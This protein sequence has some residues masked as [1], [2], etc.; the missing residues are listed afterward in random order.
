MKTITFYSYKGGVGRSLALSNI[1]R[2]LS[3]L[4]KKVCIIDFDLDAPG[5]Q[6]KFKNNY[7]IPK[8]KKGLVDY[9]YEFSL[10][11][12]VVDHIRDFSV[13]LQSKNTNFSSIDLISAGNIHS[14]EYWKKLSMVSWADMFYGED[15]RGIR[16]FL[17][18]KYKIETELQPDF[19][20]IDSRTGITDISGITLRLFADEAVVLAVNNDENIFGSK[21]IIKNLLDES[22][23]LFGKI[24]KINFVLTRIP[25]KD[26]PEDKA[27]KMRVLDNL[28]EDF[29]EHLG[30]ENFTINLI[31]SDR[32][33]EEQENQ[34]IG[35]SLEEK[36]V[37]ISNDYLKLFKLLTSDCL[38]EDELTKL[39]NSKKA[40]EEYIKG[41]RENDVKQ[42]LLHVEKAIK[43]DSSNAKYYLL[44]GH[45]FFM[46]KKYDESIN[47]QFKILELVKDEKGFSSIAISNLASIYI[48]KKEYDEAMNYIEKHISM[49]PGE[50]SLKVYK[51]KLQILKK[52]N[53]SK[54]FEILIKQLI[55]EYDIEDAELYNS[56]ADYYR[57]LGMTKEAYEDI[58]R[59]LAL[60]PDLP[61]AI[62]TL[63]EI[64]EMEGNINGFYL[65]LRNALSKGLT[66]ENMATVKD[67]YMKYE[68]DERM[69]D[70][71]SEFNMDFDMIRALKK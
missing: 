30:L 69:I 53:Q 64:N 31:H 57:E 7:T 1:A 9:I 51:L 2:R 12:K 39:E 56:R 6:F 16:F 35:Y 44:R 26:S 70:I 33:L 29:K 22:G 46:L 65:N 62:A 21:M 66:V 10:G 47:D 25:F 11:G 40:E 23:A 4:K 68:N 32:R 49:F 50:D 59:S 18:L 45:A 15:A 55:D 17:D 58:Y 63:G 52:R 67:L 42:K 28:I 61:I 24:P 19:L 36:S 20:L 37:S 27:K 41:I 14:N 38:S 13:S 54:E 34:L 48:A 3:E 60:N 8:I 71:L 5:L 43:L